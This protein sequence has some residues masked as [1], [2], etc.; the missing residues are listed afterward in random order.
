M[1]RQASV[2]MFYLWTILI[3]SM[4]LWLTSCSTAKSCHSK[5]YYV[6]KSVL[7]AQSRARN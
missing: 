7:K 6:S 3:V 1:K 2:G 4:A 5:K